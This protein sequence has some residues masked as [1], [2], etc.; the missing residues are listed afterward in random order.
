MTPLFSPRREDSLDVEVSASGYTKEMQADDELLHPIGP[1]DENTET[2][3]GSDFSF[4][5]EEVSENAEVCR[6]EIEREQ[7]F[8]DESGGCCCSLLGE[9]EQTK[10]DSLSE[11]SAEAH[12]F[13]MTEFSQALKEINGQVCENNSVTEFSEE[14]NRNDIKQDGHTGQEDIPTGSEEYEDECPHLIALSSLN[15]E[16][17]PFRYIFLLI[18]F[19]L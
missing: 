10:E 11:E 4:S 5:D 6:S 18:A 3:G 19:L 15:K 8:V 13:E 2:G 14:K 7:N 9:F 1:N 12:K 16:F 17:R